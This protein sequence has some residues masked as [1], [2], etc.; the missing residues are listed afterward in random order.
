MYILALLRHN[1][2][3]VNLE[4]LPAQFYNRVDASKDLYY[5]LIFL[6]VGDQIA[7]HSA[8]SNLDL[9]FGFTH[10]LPDIYILL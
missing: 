1:F 3:V 10:A 7:R 6:V 4:I 5:S 2:V 8:S 9:G